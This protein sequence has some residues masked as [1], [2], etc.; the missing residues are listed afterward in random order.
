MRRQAWLAAPVEEEVGDRHVPVAASTA[1]KYGIDINVFRM[2][3]GRKPKGW[4][5]AC[6]T[7]ARIHIDEMRSLLEL[8]YGESTS[9]IPTDGRTRM[10]V[11]RNGRAST[12]LHQYIAIQSV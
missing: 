7:A 9:G 2:K 4:T 1:D 6:K 8:H 3:T 5:V 10:A 12:R 11:R